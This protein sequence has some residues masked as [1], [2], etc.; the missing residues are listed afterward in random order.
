MQRILLYSRLHVSAWPLAYL[1]GL[2]HQAI[3]RCSLTQSS[4]L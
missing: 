2:S 1:A 3:R 4:R